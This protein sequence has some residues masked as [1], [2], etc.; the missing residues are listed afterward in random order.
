[1]K[2]CDRCGNTEEEFDIELYWDTQ[3]LCDICAD[4]LGAR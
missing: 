1:M 2:K 4:D 3:E